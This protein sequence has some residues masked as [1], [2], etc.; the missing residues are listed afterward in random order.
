M[1][2]KTNLNCGACVAKVKTNFDEHEGIQEWRID[3]QHIDKLLT[4]TSKGITEDEVI[5]IIRSKGFVAEA[6][7]N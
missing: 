7:H 4:V 2:F 6:I 3:T 5:D 1:T